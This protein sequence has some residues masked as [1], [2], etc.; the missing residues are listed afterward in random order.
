MTARKAGGLVAGGMWKTLRRLRDQWLLLVFAA[1][2][3]FW[4]RDVYDR[5]VDLP[6]RVEALG[7]TV[8]ELQADV[9]LAGAG[10]GDAAGQ[11]D[12]GADGRTSPDLVSGECSRRGGIRMVAAC[13]VG[14]GRGA[15]DLLTGLATDGGRGF[16][17]GVT[18]RQGAAV[19]RAKLLV[20][21]GQ[22][23]G[24]DR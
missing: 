6:A 1:S 21:P 24:A 23:C 7:R 19:G 15:A 5:F 9:R 2:A 11:Q 17:F 10:R 20:Q 12:A 4:V 3:L 18:V 13:V 16:A 22:P 8:G 14:E